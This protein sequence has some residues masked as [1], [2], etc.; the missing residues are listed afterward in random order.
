M[1]RLPRRN[2]MKIT[3]SIYGTDTDTDTEDYAM[4][5]DYQIWCAMSRGHQYDD[6]VCRADQ[7][8]ILRNIR[9]RVCWLYSCCSPRPCGCVRIELEFAVFFFFFLVQHM[10]RDGN[11][12]QRAAMS[13]YE[14]FDE[15]RF[16]SIVFYST[17]GEK[18]DDKINVV[19][20]WK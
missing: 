13:L 19:F 12:G 7:C 6:C 10:R 4:C 8:T 14:L 15:F 20:I 18:K 16:R 17:L 9:V 11:G 5:V 1:Y 2:Y 3:T